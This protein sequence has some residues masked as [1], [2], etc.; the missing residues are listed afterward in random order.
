VTTATVQEHGASCG[1]HSLEP[2]A[3]LERLLAR[4]IPG[5]FSVLI[6]GVAALTLAGCVLTAAILR[7]PSPRTHDEFSYAVMGDTLARGHVSNLSPPLHEFF[8]TFHVLVRPVYAS[9]YF[10]AQGVF[11]AIA[12]KLTGHLA[13]GVWLSTALAAAAIVWMLQAWIDPSWALLGCV[14]MALQ[15]GIFSYWS[16]SYWG[17]MVA[18]LGGALVFGAVRRLWES[19]SLQN[20]FWMALGLVILANSRPSEGLIAVLPIMLMF[21]VNIWRDRR[22]NE[23]G[24]WTKLVLPSVA[25]LALGA[26][27]TGA[28][29]RA[30]TGSPFTTP[31]ALH[32]K[33][34]QESPPLILMPMRPPIQYSSPWL[35]YYYHVQENRLWSLQR[36]PAAWI[37]TVGRKLGTWWDFYCGIWLT[38]PLILPAIL[39]KKTRYWQIANLAALLYLAITTVP[40]ETGLRVLLDISALCQIALWW[41][42]FDEF[43]SHLAITSGFLVM[44]ITLFSKWDFPHYFAPAACLVL[45]LQTQGLRQIWNWKP[46]N[47]LVDGALSRSER[48]RIAREGNNR[49]QPRFNPR[50]VVYAIPVACAL[51]LVLRVEGR[52][53]GWK[54]DPHGPERQA[55][56]M[57]DWSVRR[58]ELERWLQHESAPELVFVRYSSHH[59]VNFEW[60]YNHADIMHS[61]VIWARDLGSEHNK[62]LLNLVPDRSVWLLEADARDPQLVRYPDWNGPTANAASV[63]QTA[64][65]STDDE[66]LNW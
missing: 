1:H 42:T 59:N 35:A 57:N 19:F 26:L 50:W 58:A 6:A 5:R 3:D 28:Y 45:Y 13:V 30:I 12:E 29:N 7:E 38:I 37:G 51:A 32:E 18:A 41:A 54:E 62:L 61:H 44:F 8:E 43:W 40:H 56:L 60:V 10:P 9:K 66:K 22:W 64:A 21:L 4:L 14:L 53:K 24:F 34:Y 23:M 33:Q 11:L 27:A 25:I 47:E 63:A 17:G 48:R 65:P 36:S 15:Y 31:Y 49:V 39:K 55:L 16:Q 2:A 52:L 20:V 46:N